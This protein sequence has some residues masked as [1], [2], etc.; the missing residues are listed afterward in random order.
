MPPDF[1][2]SAAPAADFYWMRAMGAINGKCSK[3]GD[4]YYQMIVI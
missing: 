3:T 4:Y 2:K 1:M